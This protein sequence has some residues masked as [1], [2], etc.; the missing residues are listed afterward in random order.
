MNTILKIYLKLHHRLFW[1]KV[2]FIQLRALRLEYI[3]GHSA[4][5]AI[6]IVT[7]YFKNF[8]ARI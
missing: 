3:D 5:Q 1:L 8:Y 7:F 6:M 4:A 2:I